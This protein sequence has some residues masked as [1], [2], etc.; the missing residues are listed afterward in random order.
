MSS[1]SALDWYRVRLCGLLPAA[2]LFLSGC[3]GAKPPVPA[4][5]ALATK[6]V[7]TLLDTWK[8][9]GKPEDLAQKSPRILGYDC[10][11][12]RGATLVGY[13]ILPNP[14]S[15]VDTTNVHVQLER[16]VDKKK[17]KSRVMFVVTNGDPILVAREN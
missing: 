17:I 7:Q 8:G 6:A 1:R 11:W 15:V 9:G 3:G 2:W 16:L 13:D 14:H 4:D 12:A 10:D 5:P